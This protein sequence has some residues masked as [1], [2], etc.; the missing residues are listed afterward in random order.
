MKR[1]KFLINKPFQ[2]KLIFVFSLIVIF[3][4]NITASLIY[5][6]LSGAVDLSGIL[7]IT[8][9]NFL[10]P[11]IIIAQIISIVLII[12]I[13]VFLTHTMAGPIYR[14]E[15][16]IELVSEKD[17]TVKFNLRK[18]D[19][20]KNLAD[21]INSMIKKLNSELIGMENKINS[22]ENYANKIENSKEE[23]LKKITENIKKTVYE[24]TKG[25]NEFKLREREK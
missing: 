15:K 1:K 9:G 16:A 22:L 10:L 7:G 23:E 24:L 4:T 8:D 20:F 21:L 25:I 17:L 14:F 5:A 13:G 2:Y 6:F 11:S 3:S 18:D 12:I 19:E